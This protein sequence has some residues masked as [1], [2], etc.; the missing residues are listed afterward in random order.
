MGVEAGST[1][2]WRTARERNRLRAR[3]LIQSRIASRVNGD[4]RR[5]PRS[6]GGAGDSSANGNGELQL[7]LE[8]TETALHYL[9]AIIDNNLSAFSV[10]SLARDGHL[11][12]TISAPV[13]VLPSAAAIGD[14]PATILLEEAQSALTEMHSTDL[15]WEVNQRG[16]AEVLHPQPTTLAASKYGA[17]YVSERL[18]PYMQY[19][20]DRGGRQLTFV[21]YASLLGRFQT[22]SLMLLGGMDPTVGSGEYD[23]DASAARASKRVLALLHSLEGQNSPDTD[24]NEVSSTIPLSMWCYMIRSVIEMRM[25][26]ALDADRS[27]SCSVCRNHAKPLQFGPP[28]NHTFCEPCIWNHLVDTVPSC[29][30]LRR[31]VVT[32]P[33]CHVEFGGFQCQPGDQNNIRQ[34]ERREG[35]IG[36]S[37]EKKDGELPLSIDSLSLHAVSHKGKEREGENCIPSTELRAQRRSESLAKFAQLPVNSREMKSSKSK[38]RKERDPAHSTWEEALRPTV[39]SCQTRDIR[40]ERFFRAV[41]SSPHLLLSYLIA[42]VDVN[43]Q[44]VYGQSALYVACW[45]GPLVAVRLLLEYGAD[46]TIAAHGGSTCCSVA[47]AYERHDVLRLLAG[48]GKALDASIRSSVADNATAADRQRAV[49]QVSLLIDPKADHPGAGACIIDNAVSEDEIQQLVELWQ[50]L[51]TVKVDNQGEEADDFIQSNKS[52][53]KEKSSYRPSR[54]YYCDAEEEVHRMLDGCLQVARTASTED[55]GKSLQADTSNP[56]SSVFKHL[57]FLNYERPGGILPPHVD[58]CRIDDATG[59]RSSHTFILYL[60]DCEEGGGTALLNTL[61]DGKV[62]AVAQPKRGRALI[63]PHLCPHSGLETVTP[64]L[65][66]RGEVMLDMSK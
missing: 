62:L 46:A 11:L 38:R 33:C 54:S 2:R 5:S 41:L 23:G 49:P 63:F 3:Y 36:V 59:L 18:V 44:N 21:E 20:S 50:S 64:K 43:A 66:L 13:A 25:N 26:G 29:M 65:L 52:E 40:S 10:A 14:P 34:R 12:N 57:R 55:G 9:R 15:P 48:F 56:L 4:G 19:L 32:C 7:M 58:L 1:N 45:K 6:C 51:P 53:S 24:S 60:T 22:L 47:A 16:C 42:G 8:E 39:Q 27:I 37:E 35:S 61:K 31:N 28:C 17:D 30:D